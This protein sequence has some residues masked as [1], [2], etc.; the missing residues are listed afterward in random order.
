MMT[1]NLWTGLMTL[2]WRFIGLMVLSF[3]LLF[4]K[5]LKSKQ[6]CSLMRRLVMAM[7]K[8]SM[9]AHPRRQCNL[10]QP[11][12]PCPRSLK[13]HGRHLVPSMKKFW[14]LTMS[15]QLG[16]LFNCLLQSTETLF[17]HVTQR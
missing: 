5:F 15:S 13:M 16:A 1:L 10:L 17:M 7:L 4:R 3:M 6:A 8:M 11:E 2:K 14:W 9:N 12:R